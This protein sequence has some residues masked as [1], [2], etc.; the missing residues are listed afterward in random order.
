MVIR[1]GGSKKKKE[2]WG[3]KRNLLGLGGLERG[4]MG[5]G[6]LWVEGSQFLGEEK[7]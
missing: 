1:E 6:V 2:P 4:G 5:G 3:T 7:K